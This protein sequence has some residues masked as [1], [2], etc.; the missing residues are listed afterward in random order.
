MVYVG[1]RLQCQ[2]DI[3]IFTPAVMP[4]LQSQVAVEQSE[5]AVIMWN[6]GMLVQRIC[7][8]SQ[9]KVE[10]LV[11]ISDKTRAIRAL[12]LIARSPAHFQ[13]DAK[14]FLDRLQHIAMKI[15][16]KKSPGT[17][18]KRL[19]LSHQ[20]IIQHI[21]KPFA[22]SQEEVDSAKKSKG[23]LTKNSGDQIIT[24]SVIDLLA[25]NDD[26]IIYRLQSLIKH[27]SDHWQALGCIL[28]SSTKPQ[29]TDLVVALGD[30]ATTGDKFCHVMEAWI[31][32]QWRTSA[33]D[34]FLKACD[35]VDSRLRQ[36][37][38]RELAIEDGRPMSSV[39]EEGNSLQ[40]HRYH[41]LVI[42]L[43]RRRGCLWKR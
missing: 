40:V 27:C 14:Q 23:V 21:D 30:R 32:R 18:V 5:M 9:P 17:R 3:E 34:T 35:K 29:I 31:R 11:L 39:N 15:L 8:P 2:S 16:D 6:G 25:V 7:E 13:R 1:I 33:L 20:Q 12:D 43:F 41:H 4:L 24:D 36:Q 10:A 19:Y 38:N 28:L 42:Y 26:H 37:V 22:Y